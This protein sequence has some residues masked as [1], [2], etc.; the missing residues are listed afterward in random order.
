M[1][2]NA[3]DKLVFGTGGRFGR[4]AEREAFDLVDFAYSHGISIYDT[5]VAYCKGRSQKLLYKCLLSLDLPR[6]SF[7]ICTKISVCS[8]AVNNKSKIIDQL[9]SGFQSQLS[10]VDTLMLWGPSLDDLSNLKAFKM[11]R[12]LRDD[13]LIRRVGV[14]THHAHV[15]RYLI[16]NLDY[17]SLVDDLMV[18]FNL[19]Q[20]GRAEMLRDFKTSR[21]SR[22]VWAGTALCQG[23]LIQSLLSIYLR[24]RSFS[25]LARALLNPP[26]RAYLLKASPVRRLLH[27]CFGD[28]YK[29]VP[30]SFLL[31]SHSVSF[32]PL[33]MLSKS[34]IAN[35]VDIARNPVDKNLIDSFVRKM[36]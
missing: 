34:S 31:N 12:D 5:G 19:L 30:L 29:R 9:F 21:D 17:F 24:T 6:E 33:G 14:N 26:T 23:F 18:D 13:G 8:L 20:N 15:M 16:D 35:N 36:P 25:Y 1:T 7:S 4:L 27:K 10:C 11:V 28:E 32:V 2:T 22:K 3:V